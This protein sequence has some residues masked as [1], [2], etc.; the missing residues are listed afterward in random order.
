MSLISSRSRRLRG[1]VIVPGDKSVSH[2]ILMLSSQIIGITEV[3]GLLEGEDVLN[4]AKALTAMSVGIEHDAVKGI[5]RIQGVGTGGLAEPDDVIDM[6]NSGTS[7]RLLMGLLA[8]HPHTVFFT[9]DGSL[10]KRPMGRVITPLSEMGARFTA[11]QGKL[12]P[13]C[14]EGAQ[15][16]LP[17]TYTLPVASAQVK[18]AVL[19]AGLNTP[20][21]TTVIEKEPT[22]DHSERMLRFFGATVQVERKEGASH[23]AITGQPELSGNFTYQVPG[24]PSSAAF[25]TV[26]ALIVPDSEVIIRNICINPARIGLF[27]TLTEMGADLAWENVRDLQGEP[28]ADLIVRHS[29][30]KA[31]TVPAERAPSMIDEYPILAVAAAYAEGTSIFHGLKE[32][33][34]KESNRLLAIADGLSVCGI[35]VEVDGDTLRIEGKKHPTGGG[36]VSTHMDHRI[37]MSFLV[38]GM[39]SKE[40]VTIDD[41]GFIN[42]SFP[43]FGLLMNKLGGHIADLSDPDNE[44]YRPRRK[45]KVKPMV[46]AIDGPAASG[47]GT[48]A[49]RIADILDF[50]YLDT[51]SLYRAVGMKLVYGGQDPHDKKAAVDAARHIDIDDLANP[52]LRQERIGRAASI[53]AAMPEVRSALLD[54]QRQ[55][56]GRA[57]GAVLDG[58][59]IGT[60]VCPDADVKLFI[61]ASLGARARRR[62]REIQGQGVEVVFASV[63]KDLEERDQRDRE[64]DQAPMRPA[65]DAIIIDT[66]NLTADDVLE[67]ALHEIKLKSAVKTSSGSVPA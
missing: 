44:E 49:R 43:G 56:A 48:L 64:R 5:W 54:F 10:R 37:A 65:D 41:G 53:V 55:F 9:G 3:T 46:I 28:V 13:L 67:K 31:V 39:N 34:V 11:R 59:D 29:E 60:V 47:K 6:G 16:P 8:S 20:G 52:R 50:R 22:R 62:H 36:T 32:L 4:T 19:L 35:T 61:T 2:R 1:D 63:L 30:L 7:T 25:L 33:T 66:T 18:S 42:T 45:E 12:L 26:A 21:I 58:R 24:D 17:I 51:G 40:P 27:E 14:L 23:I 15:T 57:G 38:F